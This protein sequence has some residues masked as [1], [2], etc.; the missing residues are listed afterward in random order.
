MIRRMLPCS[1]TRAICPLSNVRFVVRTPLLFSA[2]TPRALKLLVV[3][4]CYPTNPLPLLPQLMYLFSCGQHYHEGLVGTLLQ[5]GDF[6]DTGSAGTWTDGETEEFVVG[7][8]HG[9][10]DH[11]TAYGWV[12]DPRHGAVVSLPLSSDESGSGEPG[13][14]VSRPYCIMKSQV[15]PQ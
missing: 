10:L 5:S 9:R 11:L 2:P 15:R 1:Y 8:D 3:P 6:S 4:K 12:P 13:S 7:H 14:L